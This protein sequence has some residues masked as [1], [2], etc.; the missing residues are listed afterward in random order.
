[1][2]KYADNKKRYSKILT[3]PIPTHPIAKIGGLQ[4]PVTDWS[5]CTFVQPFALRNAGRSH[6]EIFKMSHSDFRADDAFAQFPDL[7]TQ[8]LRM[9]RTMAANWFALQVP[10]IPLPC[11]RAS[12]KRPFSSVGISNRWWTFAGI[13]LSLFKSLQHPQKL[14]DSELTQEKCREEFLAKLKAGEEKWVVTI[15][16]FFFWGAFV[17]S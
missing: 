10:Q 17:P 15:G 7:R 8:A 16:L 6:P 5:S 3:I 14:V 9:R 13:V 4:N 12:S 2:K 11:R 1:M